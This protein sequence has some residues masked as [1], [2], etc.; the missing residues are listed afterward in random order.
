MKSKISSVAEHTKCSV[1]LT[2]MPRLQYPT[3]VVFLLFSIGVMESYQIW[4][5]AKQNQSEKASKFQLEI[6][7]LSRVFAPRYMQTVRFQKE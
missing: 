5:L 1:I 7:P 6:F 3:P 4:I 2:K